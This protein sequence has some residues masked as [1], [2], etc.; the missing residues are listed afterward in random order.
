MTSRETVL[1]ETA[2]DLQTACGFGMALL[3]FGFLLIPIVGHGCH[4]DDVDHEPVAGP[5]QRTKEK[6]P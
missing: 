3:L 6:T 1:G 2:S 5:H 4:G